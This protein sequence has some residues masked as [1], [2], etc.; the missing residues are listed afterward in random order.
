MAE[1]W[2]EVKNPFGTNMK[3]LR[4]EPP[5]APGDARLR[6]TK[7]PAGA[8]LIPLAET[9]PYERKIWMKR[10]SEE[11]QAV[12]FANWFTGESVWAGT[13]EAKKI[14][15]RLEYVL[16]PPSGGERE[17]FEEWYKANYTPEGISAKA[18]QVE[19]AAPAPI[20]APV[21]VKKSDLPQLISQA[22]TLLKEKSKADFE[23]WYTKDGRIITTFEEMYKHMGEEEE[24][25]VKKSGQLLYI[26]PNI[27]IV[28]F[29]ERGQKG[30]IIT[31]DNTLSDQTETEKIKQFFKFNK[32]FIYAF[33]QQGGGHAVFCEIEGNTLYVNDPLE[34]KWRDIFERDWDLVKPILDIAFEGREYEIESRNTCSFQGK[35]GTCQLNSLLLMMLTKEQIDRLFSEIIEEKELPKNK[36]VKDAIILELFNIMENILQSRRG[37]R[38]SRRCIKCGKL[39][40]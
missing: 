30:V 33:G 24:T 20:Q 16:P 11:D 5:G 3:Y 1:T 38:K 36:D 22:I 35:R 21:L 19:K 18:S 40:Y 2:I 25:I 34:F 39:K 4:V 14:T 28:F 23:K 29:E 6:S 8:K 12:W 32:K 9:G 37:G 7:P 26:V 31:D 27:N 17:K 10:F 13:P 15:N